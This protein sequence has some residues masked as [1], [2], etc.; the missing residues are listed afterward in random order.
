M[1]SKRL[2]LYQRLRDFKIPSTILDAIFENDEDLKILENAFDAL[3]KDGF[4]EDEAAEEISKMIFDEL[5]IEPNQS[6]NV[7]K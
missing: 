4:K 6:F 3:V 1:D 5:D 2:S 7:E